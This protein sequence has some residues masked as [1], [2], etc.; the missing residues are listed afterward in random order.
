MNILN[1]EIG[2]SIREDEIKDFVKYRND[3]THGNH[4]VLDKRIACTA[5]LLSGLV[6]CSLLD[7]IGISREKIRELCVHKLLR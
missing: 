4:R 5:H 6:Y 1:R 7:R 3:I 2:I